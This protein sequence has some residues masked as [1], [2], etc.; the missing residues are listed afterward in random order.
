MHRLLLLATATLRESFGVRV[1]VRAVYD[2]VRTV[3][4][5]HAHPRDNGLC[6]LFRHS[7]SFVC[8]GAV[9]APVP[10]TAFTPH[11]EK[12]ARLQSRLQW[13]GDKHRQRSRHTVR[14][15]HDMCSGASV[16]ALC[17]P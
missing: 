4:S 17:E 7:L 10:H 15:G 13:R 9:V 2:A 3:V 5:M 11:S 6:R 14:R 8:R 16:R 12:R 1:S